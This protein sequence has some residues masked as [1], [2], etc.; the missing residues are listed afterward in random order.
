MSLIRKFLGLTQIFDNNE[1]FISFLFCVYENLLIFLD[2]GAASKS[3]SSSASRSRISF[4]VSV[5]RQRVEHDSA[6][7]DKLRTVFVQRSDSVENVDD[8]RSV[9]DKDVSEISGMSY[10]VKSKTII[11]V[12]TGPEDHL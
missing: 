8:C 4:R 2:N 1:S 3:R 9:I 11:V 7:T 6:V 12:I 10:E 5:V